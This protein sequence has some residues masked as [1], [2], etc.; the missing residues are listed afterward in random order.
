MRGSAGG[1]HLHPVDPLRI[2]PRLRRDSRAGGVR[3]RT[4]LNATHGLGY[5]LAVSG[6]RIVAWPLTGW[7]LWGGQPYLAE[8]IV[9]AGVLTVG[10]AWRLAATVSGLWRTPGLRGDSIGFPVG[11]ADRRVRERD[12]TWLVACSLGAMALAL[13]LG[14]RETSEISPAF[15]EHYHLAADPFVIVA[16]SL[17]VGAVWRLRVRGV[18]VGV[19]GRMVCI[20]ALVGSAYYSSQEWSAGPNSSSWS[21][22]QTAAG[23]IENDASGRSLALVGLPGHRSTDAY[24][25]PLSLDGTPLVAPDR[26]E[27]LVI[28]CDSTWSPTCGGPAEDAWLAA[29]PYAQAFELLDR[30]EAAPKRTLSVFGRLSSRASGSDAGCS[31]YSAHG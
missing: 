4:R 6:A 12:G 25:Y 10:T 24:G 1:R 17:L 2:G 21:V 7:P 16:A 13:G 28:L 5:R 31:S 29:Q 26:A 19:L 30:F 3:Y 11:D 9:V 23:R 14:I 22:A 27:V 18:W 15:I 8:A 20:V